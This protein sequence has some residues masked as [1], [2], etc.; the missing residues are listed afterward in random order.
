M[1]LRHTFECRALGR[2]WSSYGHDRVSDRMGP[3]VST[4]LVQSALNQNA[5]VG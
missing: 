4:H 1:A 5:L 2:Y 3:S